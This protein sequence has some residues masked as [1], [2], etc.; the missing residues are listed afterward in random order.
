MK[1]DLIEKIE[2]LLHLHFCEQEGL[3][4]G[5]PTAE[6]WFN[7][8]NELSDELERIKSLP[9]PIL[10]KALRKKGTDKWY[11][12]SDA[13]YEVWDYPD[14]WS[15]NILLKPSDA[16]LDAELIDI[17]IYVKPKEK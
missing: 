17:E 1:T 11:I 14:I 15:K 2:A 4:S 5:K 3:L 7:A 9:S 8:V 13:D 12:T 16:P 6:Q 10:A